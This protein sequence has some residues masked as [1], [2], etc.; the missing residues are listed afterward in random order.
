MNE[1]QFFILIFFQQAAVNHHRKEAHLLELVVK[2]LKSHQ[3]FS[4]SLSSSSS[5]PSLASPTSTASSKPTLFNETEA[6]AIFINRSRLCSNEK[7][8]FLERISD[9]QLHCLTDQIHTNIFKMS[10]DNANSISMRSSNLVVPQENR[11]NENGILLDLSLKTTNKYSNLMINDQLVPL[12]P[13]SNSSAT[14]NGTSSAI[15]NKSH[16]LSEVATKQ[17]I[18]QKIRSNIL[19]KQR[20]QN[21]LRCMYKKPLALDGDNN[22]TGGAGGGR[23]NDSMWRPW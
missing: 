19:K 14:N 21:I 20:L 7:V 10:N 15:Q 11:S 17:E 23:R 8:N 12:A 13:I 4:S 5:S 6:M 3:Q 18:L 1:K 2:H 16:L 22:G 9:I